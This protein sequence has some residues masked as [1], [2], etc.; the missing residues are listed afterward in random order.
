MTPPSGIVERMTITNTPQNTLETPPTPTRWGVLG[1]GSIATKFATQVAHAHRSTI[2]AVGS[3][4]QGS[5]DKFGDEHAIGTRHGSYADLFAD[6]NIQAVY[7][8]APHTEH[9]RL[10]LDAIAAGKAVLCEK[11]LATSAALAEAMI[12]AARRAQV[13]LMEAF[14]YRCH[15][16]TARIVELI[17]DGAIG[18]VRHI[19]AQFGFN[20]GHDRVD[21]R[22]RNPDLGGG[23]ILDVGCYPVSF[24]RLIAG[25]TAHQPFA[26]PDTVAASGYL[27]PTGVDDAAFALLAFHDGDTTAHVATA[28]RLNLDNSATIYGESGILRVPQ[29]WQ[30]SGRIAQTARFDLIRAGKPAETI[31]VDDPRPLFAI[32]ADTVSAAIAA[33]K[34]QPDPPAMTWE[35]T[36]GNMRTLDQWRAALKLVYPFETPE[37]NQPIR[38]IGSLQSAA[39]SNIKGHTDGKTNDTPGMTYAQVEGLAKPISRFVIGCD[40]SASYEASAILWDEWAHCGGNAFDTAYVYGGGK[41]ETLL[42]QWVKSRNIRD[43]IVVIGKG[44]HTPHCNPEALTRQLHETLDRLGMDRVDLYFMHR[45]NTDIPVGEFVD[46]L[47]EH[48]D[49]GLIGPFGGSN[50]TRQRFEEAQAYATQN[51]KRPPTLLSN[52]LSLARMQKPVWT[53]AISFS[54]EP[55]REYLERSNTPLFSW[56]SQARGYF[57]DRSQITHAHGVPLDEAWDSPDNR[58]RRDRTIELAKKHN[59]TPINIA[60]AYVL[61]QSFPTFALIGPRR[62]YELH[63]SLPALSLNLSSEELAYLDLRA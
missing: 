59:V 18:R 26:N 15:P 46:V 23:G 47:N 3:R 61:S 38:G 52:N 30:P 12:E 58:Q 5:A 19:H 25:T 33:G 32:E 45:D 51:N 43:S 10:T 24:A 56:S 1:T 6:E 8:A 42:G 35:D 49:A 63:T 29:P 36:L 37:H 41:L 28:V 62:Q 50:W 54:D 53:G 7:I 40:N 11:P 48:H 9:P 57:A 27:G 22:L 2:V 60:A 17:R 34:L 16:Q 31:E 13:F 4:S 21:H 20:A 39:R 44:A 14:M 55:H